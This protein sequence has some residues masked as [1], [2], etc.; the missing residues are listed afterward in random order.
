MPELKTDERFM[1]LSVPASEADLEKLKQ[2]LLNEGCNEPIITWKKII[3]DG[4]KRYKICKMF[5]IDYSVIE[6]DFVTG[7]EAVVFVCRDRVKQVQPFTPVYRYLVGKWF[8][9]LKEKYR[10]IQQKDSTHPLKITDE[11][12]KA[13]RAYDRA[14]K[15]IMNELNISDS[16]ITKFGTFSEIMD[17]IRIITPSLFYDILSGRTLVAYQEMLKL[18]HADEMEIKR[19]CRKYA[20]TDEIRMRVRT[21]NN[22]KKSVGSNSD[23]S[24]RSRLN[25]GVKE[26]PVSDPD[27]E[28]RGL[29]FT[30][31]MWIS[32]ISRAM[33]HTDIEKSTD[34][35]KNQLSAA[36]TKLDE[37]IK[38]TLEALK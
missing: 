31:P 18:A 34:T 14:T 21:S 20:N 19:F 1:S 24:D 12:G 6:K 27:R 4:H 15:E 35:A 23:I 7:G 28:L 33:N 3:L 16:S 38:N 25:T 37:Q 32:A 5:K 22:K 9:N 30:V 36:L 11:N 8:V 13:I 2:S 17:K 26:M 29:T 10:L